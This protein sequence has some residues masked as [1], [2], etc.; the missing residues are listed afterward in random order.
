MKLPLAQFSAMLLAMGLFGLV[1]CTAP[2]QGENAGLTALAT[3]LKPE[4]GVDTLMLVL[5]ASST[6]S[7]AASSLVAMVL[8]STVVTEGLATE[9]NALQH[10]VTSSYAAVQAL[11]PGC[12][13]TPVHIGKG[14]ALHHVQNPKGS[15]P[16]TR[17]VVDSMVVTDYAGR[18]LP[19]LSGSEGW[20]PPEVLEYLKNLMDA[21]LYMEYWGLE[22][23]AA[24]PGGD[25]INRVALGRL[26][27]PERK[28][29]LGSG[30]HAKRYYRTL[31]WQ[32]GQWYYVAV[33]SVDHPDMAD[34]SARVEWSIAPVPNN[35]L[36]NNELVIDWPWLKYTFQ[37]VTDVYVSPTRSHLLLQVQ[38]GDQQVLKL[39]H[40]GQ[41]KLL[42]SIPLTE[43][44]RLLACNW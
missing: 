14:V 31:R 1:S 34:G 5:S 44:R 32:N 38:E 39:Y 6:D 43:G 12:Q 9:A 37:S 2:P 23:L 19:W 11:W 41:G 22:G 29:L 25:T 4:V 30:F 8:D 3:L 18:P 24:L 33:G 35:R 7:A 28:N 40:V 16:A 17:L 42:K 13:V 27:L 21:R 20:L 10:S 15:M 26:T 36:A